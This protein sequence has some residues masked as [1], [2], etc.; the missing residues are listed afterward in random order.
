MTT[1]TT[2]DRSVN[3]DTGSR[4][5]SI[6]AGRDINRETYV[7]EWAEAGLTV[8]DSPYD[9]QPSLR[10]VDDE[11]V[12]MDGKERADFD[13]LD[14]FIADHALDMA[15]AEEAMATSSHQIARM[16]VD[17]NVPQPTIRRLADGCTPA[18][19][20]EKTR[21]CWPRMRPRPRCAALPRSRRRCASRAP[22]RSTRSRFSSVRRP[23]AAVCSPSARLRRRL[24]CA[25]ASKG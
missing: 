3:G 1:T 5:F 18:K 6:L 2:A 19:L 11:V 15:V 10:I 25:W 16:L 14:R 8:A 20:C 7:E 17:I 13:A 23:A 9:P 12:E 22:R 24:A 21:L 4:R